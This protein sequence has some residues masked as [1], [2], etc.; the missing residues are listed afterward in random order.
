LTLLWK[1]EAYGNDGFIF[2]KKNLSR[3]RDPI[4]WFL[5]KFLP[6]YAKAEP[7]VKLVL[8]MLFIAVLVWFGISL[9]PQVIHV[10]DYNFTIINS[11]S[12][13]FSFLLP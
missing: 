7:V 8:D 6:R 12:G 9:Q 13:N 11:T 3:M 10:C 5:E 4:L 2:I 1:Q